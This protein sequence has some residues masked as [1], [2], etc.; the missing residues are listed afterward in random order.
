M[1]FKVKKA[2]VSAHPV[3]VFFERGWNRG[4]V[5]KRAKKIHIK[6][7]KGNTVPSKKLFKR[8]RTKYLKKR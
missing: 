6:E 7:R 1:S 8:M 2:P 4:W 3:W 5:F